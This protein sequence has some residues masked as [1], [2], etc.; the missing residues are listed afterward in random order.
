M[1]KLA[2][3]LLILCLSLLVVACNTTTPTPAESSK[4]PAPSQS[5]AES[6][7]AT[8]AEST[9][10]KKELVFAL[11]PK[12]LTNPY[13]VAMQEFAEAEA[14]KLGVKI[15]SIAP[16][17]ETKVEEQIAMFETML[18]K[19]V[20]AILIVPCGTTE[21]VASIEKANAL[22]IPVICLDTNA[23]GGEITS[24]I[25][26]NNYAGGKLAG[27]WV[28]DNIGSGKVSIITGTPGNKTH[29]DRV[30]GFLE[31]ISGNADIVVA[32][33]VV[34]AYSDRAQGM[35][36]AE[37]LITANPDIVAIYCTNDEMAMGAGEAVK[38]QGLSDQITVIGF[39]GAPSSAQG[40]LD[41]I[42]HASVAQAPGKMAQ[43]G[44]QAAYELIVNGVKP[45]AEVD[46]GCT[47][48]TIDNAQEYLNWH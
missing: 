11:L 15:E 9:P 44:V 19:N 33:D 38:A 4:A 24:F 46:T 12:T 42:M 32:G 5:A 36:Q 13:F 22:G 47:M 8:P 17:D 37:N 29:E 45:E 31:G 14:A 3:L 23:S 26:T 21:I 20:D 28:S 41:G 1:K 40:I 34:P 10:E 27:E 2:A 48:V 16:P 30:N 39:D 7:P 35:S 25:G 43:M 18:E 6:K